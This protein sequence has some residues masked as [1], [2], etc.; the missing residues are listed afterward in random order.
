MSRKTYI[1]VFRL[2]TAVLKR[3]NMTYRFEPIKGKC[4]EIVE[5]ILSDNLMPQDKELIFKIR[6]CVEE[7]A[8]NIVQYAYPDGDGW[9]EAS[10]DIETSQV[11]IEFKDSGSPFD[12]LAKPDPD[13]TLGVEDRPIG[14]L[15]IFLCKQFMDS[16]DY[17]YEDGCNILKMSKKLSV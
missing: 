16:I 1:C 15:G 7:V 3:S 13:L 9:M 8:E 4:G 10:V 12:P 6:L 5:S 2:I 17:R 11:S 14:G